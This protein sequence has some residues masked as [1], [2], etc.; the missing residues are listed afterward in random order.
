MIFSKEKLL[1]FLLFVVLMLYP[2]LMFGVF[3]SDKLRIFL[4]II[5]LFFLIVYC[6]DDFKMDKKI[7]KL[8]ILFI[9][10]LGAVLVNT[11]NEGFW[12]AI[13]FS[14]VILFSIIFF[15]VLN[16]DKYL[17]FR[18]TILKLYVLFFVVTGICIAL[19]F[20]I[21][22][23]S[24]GFSQ[25]FALSGYDVKMSIFGLNATKNI[26]GFNFHKNWFYFIEPSYIAFFCLINIFFIEDKV[27]EKSRLFF[28]ANL[29]GGILSGSFLFYL[30]GILLWM[31]HL[32][33][34]R[35]KGTSIILLLLIPF[36]LQGLLYLSSA[37]SY[38]DRLYRIILGADLIGKMSL[39]QF[40]FGYG[41]IIDLERGISAGVFSSFVEGGIF[42]LM[43]P[44]VLAT[45]YC[46]GE[47]GLI[48]LL[49]MGLFVLELF[50]WPLFWGSIILAGSL[51]K[52][53]EGFY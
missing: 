30:G 13:N 32:F 42:G 31:S 7:L 33:L 24:A 1:A 9:M 18:S 34:T 16:N 3:I 37:S 11:P 28:S 53:K 22:M 46:K 35:K 45:I 4:F 23:V 25:P 21:N 27:T 41:N 6:L 50:Q 26:L 14:A 12:T 39:S 20:L 51:S 17:K 36:T 48:L 29:L 10:Y 8:L 44:L 49:I 47:K 5:A 19:N 38:S 52:N 15:S 40:F 2:P 43:V